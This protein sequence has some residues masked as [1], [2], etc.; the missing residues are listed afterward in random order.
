VA[1]GPPRGGVGLL[2]AHRLA[3]GDA[4]AHHRLERGA[5]SIRALPA[6]TAARAGAWLACSFALYSTYDLL[7]RYT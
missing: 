1:L 6:A 4:G 7:G 5:R 3:A 2:R